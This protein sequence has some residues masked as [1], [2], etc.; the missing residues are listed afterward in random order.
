[1]YLFNTAGFLKGKILLKSDCICATEYQFKNGW[2][3]GHLHVILVDIC[4]ERPERP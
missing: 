1:M 2:M 3:V 4:G